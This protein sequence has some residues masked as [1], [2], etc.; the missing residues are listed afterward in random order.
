MKQ[1]DILII[2]ILLFIFVIAW[3]GSGLYH[4]AVSST[5]SETTAQDISPIAPTF[6]NK[7]IGNLKQ[8]KNINS[9][10]ELIELSPTPT[11]SLPAQNPSS[12]SAPAKAKLEI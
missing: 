2:L 11:P 10:F 8:R 6:D 9:S 5:I 4:S 12:E 3:I 7:T 1:K